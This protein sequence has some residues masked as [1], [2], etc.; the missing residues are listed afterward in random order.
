MHKDGKKSV[1]KE[2]REG[3]VEMKLYIDEGWGVRGGK[4]GGLYF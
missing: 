1:G 2:W 4:S 3:S